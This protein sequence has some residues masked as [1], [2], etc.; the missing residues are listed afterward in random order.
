[1]VA[2]VMA[3]GNV[4]QYAQGGLVVFSDTHLALRNGDT[5]MPSSL[6]TA[7]I[8]AAS[9]LFAASENVAAADALQPAELRTYSTWHSIGVE[10]DVRG[11]ANHNAKCDVQYRARGSG[12]WRETLPL[13]RIDYHGWYGDTKADRAY[14]MLAGSILFLEPGTAYEVQLV[15]TD[16]DGGQESRTVVVGTRPIPALPRGGRTWHVVPGGGGGDGTATK[17]FCGLAAAQAAAQAGD[18]I[19]V[20]RGDYG[21][22]S[23]EKPGAP[24]RYLAWVAA[25]D[26][27]PVLNHATVAASHVWLQGLDFQRGADSPNGLRV[28]GGPVEVVLS[29]NRFHGYHYSITLSREA[30]DWYIAD[31]T[32]V[33]D[34]VNLDVSD[35]SGEGIEL[36]HSSGHAVAFNRISRVADGIS[37]PYRNCDLYGND[38]RDVT[39]DGIEPDYGY[40]NIRIWGNRIHRAFNEGFSFQPQYCG[41]W[42]IVRNEVFSRRNM[43]K[44]NVADRF[45]LVNNTLV[46][47]SRYA[48]G[49][50]DLVLKSLSRNNLWILLHQWNER[51]PT[52]AIWHTGQRKRGNPYS[53]EYQALPDWRTDV[54]YD[55]F[56]WDRTPT[57]FWWQL[58]SE[59]L[60]HFRDLASF[61]K[62]VGIEQ[63]GVRVR[64][65]EVFSVS[66]L[67]AYFAEPFPSRRLTLKPGSAAVD[68]GQVLPN[69]CDDFIG[70]APDLGAHELGRPAAHYGPRPLPQ[71]APK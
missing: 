48:Q 53:M 36:N 45:V 69:L 50:A 21:M 33:G 32:I 35:I 60:E 61:S 68:A 65:E 15:V 7:A 2:S 49:S 31:N 54:D 23:F 26:G 51:E 52:Y 30:R 57:P 28:H 42:Y 8:G 25:G 27:E 71:P 70:A 64:K 67:P 43:L 9:M 19:L 55:G 66:D 56:D 39:D 37:Y 14:N 16:P 11:D 17:P 5:R 6:I 10:W 38:I 22:F 29:R 12:H 44:P 1:M 46:V 40:A 4:E 62:A 41:P 24:N 20:H 3:N 58:K 63:H 18:V 13:F 59:K 34:K 47:Q